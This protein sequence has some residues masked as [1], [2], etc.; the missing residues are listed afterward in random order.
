MVT[1]MSFTI[2]GAALT[3]GVLESGTQAIM[4]AGRRESASFSSP[5]IVAVDKGK[6]REVV[7]ME[8]GQRAG[9]VRL[10]K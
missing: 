9:S 1:F 3:S 5:L 4:R 2:V 7:F 10:K 8:N 6:Y